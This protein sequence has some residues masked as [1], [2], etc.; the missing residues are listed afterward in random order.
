MKPK[1]IFDRVRKGVTKDNQIAIQGFCSEEFLEDLEVRAELSSAEGK[2]ELPCEM[3]V[4]NIPALKRMEL[5]D[6]DISRM[7][8]VLVNVGE[9]LAV[10]SQL[11]VQGLISQDGFTDRDQI[12]IYSCKGKRLEAI[13]KELNVCVETVFAQ[14]DKLVIKGWAAD[15]N[16]LDF[17]V[18][19]KKGN[20]PIEI[21]SKESTI[22]SD[23]ESAF[24]EKDDCS[25]V[26][27]LITVPHIEDR[28][29]FQVVAG[30]IIYEQ[31][32]EW[33]QIS[34][35]GGLVPRVKNLARK[36]MLSLNNNGLK[37]TV[38]KINRRIF[39]RFDSKPKEYNRWFN[40]HKATEEE[41]AKQREAHF[42][43]EPAFSILVPL[44]ETDEK[45]LKELIESV[46]AQS[47]VKWELCFSDGSKDSDRLS[48]LLKPY[49]EQDERIKYISEKKG[50]LG[51]SDNTNQALELATGEYIVLG[52]HDDLF[53]PNALYECVKVLNKEKWDVI[54]TDEDKIDFKG[55]KHFEPH[56][57]PDF[58][59]DL[60]RSNNYICHM[61][62]AARSLIDQVGMFDDS[63]DGAQDYDFVLRCVDK[64]QSIYHIPKILYHWRSHMAST[65]SSPEAKL[66]AFEAGKKALEAHY[67][68]RGLEATVESIEEYG[69]Y[70][71]NYKI[72]DN[73]K[74]SI[75]IPN[76][77]HIED[78]MKCMD[79][80]DRLSDYRNYEFIVVENNST[81]DRT[82]EF[83][84]SIED[85]D[86]V[87]VL[88]W[89]KEFNYSAIN[90]F[91]VEAAD[92]EYILLLNNDTEI[93]NPD[94]L[95]QMLGY[96]Q[97][98]DVGIVGARL[99]YEDGSIQH[100]GVVIGFGGIAGHAFVGLYEDNG[101]YM[102]RTKVACNYSAVTAACL[103]VKKS[104]F[105]QVG[106]LDESFKV[107]FND[108]DFC[109][110]VRE[111]GKLVVY[112]PNA[113]LYHYESKSRGYEDT[114]EK[115]ARFASEIERF[116]KKWPD[117]LAKGD[118]YYNENLALDKA[119][120]SVKG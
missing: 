3:K 51:I 74:I 18:F 16:Q 23:L 103:M 68:R 115:Q 76:K 63:F 95:S 80:I 90:N 60:L 54:Y 55:K 14:G 20:K 39:S 98:E 56:F 26:G 71:T 2:V 91:G 66:Y 38:K 28:M 109:M 118:P 100:A 99:Y 61:F 67:K 93:I 32:V 94:C 15:N 22:R 57:K 58:N 31:T 35:K 84:K 86:N 52:D 64:A 88:Y 27:F 36:T 41:L 49:M 120:F 108:I 24:V 81:E 79:S 59:I 72:I 83:Y 106:G 7:L 62:V 34:S 8:T 4:S 46:K 97:R 1:F 10:N 40:E 77:D 105:Q 5:K 117:I 6:S 50:P 11:I 29:K 110:M 107:A 102:S 43:Y 114:P 21:I 12:E 119:D 17:Q 9:N 92:G 53:A 47:Y 33:T 44:Y 116:S 69:F 78:L 70:R 37:A 111:L 82:F 30:D 65:A 73:P 96:C 42:E 113:K 25:N 85:R 19:S 87:K 48:K 112:N 13:T 104:I 45:F 101:L 89:D 75:V